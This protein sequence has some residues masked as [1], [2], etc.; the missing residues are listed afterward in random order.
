MIKTKY[1]VLSVC[2]LFGMLMVA[3]PVA[4]Q[5]YA[6]S[7]SSY[8][9]GSLSSSLSPAK[10]AALQ[11]YS[12][13][14]TPVNTYEGLSPQKLTAITG[15]QTSAITPAQGSVSAFSS[16]SSRTNTTSMAFSQSVSVQGEIYS[17][18]FITTFT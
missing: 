15:A 8:G 2:V 11:G 9:G 7:V 1:M 10:Q 3:A 18:E 16:Y 13:G 17:F 5:S 6:V 14:I 12:S 4:A